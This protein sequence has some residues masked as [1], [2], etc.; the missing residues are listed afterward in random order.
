MRT[1]LFFVF[2]FFALAASTLLRAWQD[3]N[4][5][6]NAI[7]T[8]REYFRKKAVLIG[9][10]AVACTG[11]FIWWFNDPSLVSKLFD[12]I[13]SMFSDPT[14]SIISAIEFPLNVGTAMIYGVSCD[15]VLDKFITWVNAKFK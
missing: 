2:Y 4:D 13:G 15:S 11:F 5:S 7:T 8:Y 6:D 3:V 9:V 12:A 1:A 10:R 14:K